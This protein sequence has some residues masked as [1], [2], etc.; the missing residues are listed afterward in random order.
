MHDQHDI[1]GGGRAALPQ[2]DRPGQ[3]PD[4]QHDRDQRRAGGA[5]SRDRA[6]CAGAPPSRGRR[7]VEA[8]LLAAEA[9]ER[10]HQRHVADDVDHLA[11]DRRGLVGEIVM[12]RL[13]GGG[14]AEHARRP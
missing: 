6:G 11:V 5:A 12:Q 7:R 4:R 10:A 13:A 9:A 8:A 2:H 14:Q 1:A 3:Q